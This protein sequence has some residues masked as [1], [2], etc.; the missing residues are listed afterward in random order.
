MVIG[1]AF[2]A[3]FRKNKYL[4]DYGRALF[5]YFV[6]HHTTK[7]IAFKNYRSLPLPLMAALVG[8][9]G[10]KGYAVSVRLD[11]DRL[12]ALFPNVESIRFGDLPLSRMATDAEGYMMSVLEHIKGDLDRGQKQLKKIEFRSCSENEVKGNDVRTLCSSVISDMVKYTTKF[13]KTRRE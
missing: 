13:Q 4:T 6:R 8:R 7:E 10:G 12:T 1:F 2:Y 11:I 5:D 9:G 3:V